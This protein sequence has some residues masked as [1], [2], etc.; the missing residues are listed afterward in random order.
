MHDELELLNVLKAAAKL[1]SILLIAEWDIEHSTEEQRAH[2]AAAE[3]Q[4]LYNAS[5]ETDSN[6]QTLFTASDLA[7]LAF[8]AGFSQSTYKQVEAEE[9][10]DGKWE[11]DY[12]VTLSD[13][14]E[15]DEEQVTVLRNII[16]QSIK[17]VSLHS[18][19]L[20]CTKG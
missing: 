17:I 4:V 11:V 20:I 19:V 14:N 8:E 13:F 5:H 3:L 10:Q 2:K 7:S 1:T 18:A 9:L 12:A 16:M 6:I 15:K